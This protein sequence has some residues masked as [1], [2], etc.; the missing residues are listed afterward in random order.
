MDGR[1]VTLFSWSCHHSLLQCYSFPL[2]CKAVDG[3]KS[4][5]VFFIYSELQQQVYVGRERE[6]RS[7]VSKCLDLF[8]VSMSLYSKS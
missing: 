8:N 5:W 3:V 1:A 6:D 7:L 4:F 2:P